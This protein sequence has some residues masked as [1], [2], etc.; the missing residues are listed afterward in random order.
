MNVIIKAV[1]GR[2]EC[3]KWLYGKHLLQNWWPKIRH[4]WRIRK[5]SLLW[6]SACFFFKIWHFSCTDLSCRLPGITS[7][8][9]KPLCTGDYQ[10]IDFGIPNFINLTGWWIGGG[11][12]RS[13]RSAVGRVTTSWSHFPSTA[14]QGE[15]WNIFC[16]RWE[17]NPKA[18]V[19]WLLGFSV[20]TL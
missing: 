7:P 18:I 4:Q 14:I 11:W 2:F 19:H 1:K 3:T 13:R 10:I 5:H 8:T 9:Y 12:H 20:P 17:T 6:V 15:S 16:S